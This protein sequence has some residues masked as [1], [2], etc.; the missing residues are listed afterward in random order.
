MKWLY[1]FLVVFCLA[2][3]PVFAAPVPGQI[4]EVNGLEYP[5]W[6]VSVTPYGGTLLLSDSPETVKE[7]GILYQDTVSGSLRVFMYHLNGTGASKKVVVTLE[8]PGDKPVKV[9]LHKKGYGGPGYNY[10]EVGKKAEQTYLDSKGIETITLSPKELRLLDSSLGRIVVPADTLVNGIYDFLADGP[11][12]VKVMSMPVDANIGKF[13]AK[14]KILPN[15]DQRLRGTFPGKDRLIIPH[16]LYRGEQDGTVTIALADPNKDGYVT[17][18]DATDGSPALN[19]GNY[20]VL[21]RIFLPGESG[22]AA[23]LLNPRGGEYAGVMGIQ[24]KHETSYTLATPGDRL[25]FGSTPSDSAYL[26]TFD[27]SQSLWLTFSPPGASNLPVKL[28]LRPGEVAE[29]DRVKNQ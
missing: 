25:F 19:Y 17:G 26:G 9:L 16:R 27:A 10:M 1:A 7:D 29:K 13:A 28:I 14:A 23:Y 21:Y 12:T 20:G 22:N 11:V 4:L 5:E 18:I 8:N 24:Y 2:A 6:P 3:A 15:D